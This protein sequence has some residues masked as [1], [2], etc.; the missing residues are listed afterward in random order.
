[1]TQG[2]QISVT[3]AV[4]AAPG[5]VP[6]VGDEVILVVG[7]DSVF[8]RVIDIELHPCDTDAA[9]S[10][11]NSARWSTLAS[12][13]VE[14]KSP[15]DI[16]IA[17]RIDGRARTVVLLEAVTQKPIASGLIVHCG[18]VDLDPF[19]KVLPSSRGLTIWLTGLS[20]A[21][22]TTI[23]RA[24]EQRL[25]GKVSVEMLDADMVR[26]HICK[27][28]GFT[29]EDRGENVRRLALLADTLAERRAVVLVSSIS[30][31]RAMRERARRMINRF[32]EVYVNAPLEVCE[33]RDVKGLYKR[34]R[35]GEVKLFTGIG[36]RYEAPLYPEIECRTDLESVEESVA[37]I[38][39][40]IALDLD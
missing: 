5:S 9:D 32:I 2:V 34:A 26:T 28:L 12:L 20:G 6:R 13:N 7:E 37:K 8:G 31:Y 24:L 3:T 38:L 22:K 21:G 27:G 16:D 35:Q 40:A 30:P 33:A 18:R 4:V 23:G 15:H 11:V 1:M 10:L 29:E 17:S 14:S 39:E 25:L 36:D 19:S